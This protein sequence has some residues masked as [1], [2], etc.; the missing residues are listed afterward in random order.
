MYKKS[1]SRVFLDYFIYEINSEK[2]NVFSL[3]QTSRIRFSISTFHNLGSKI[4]EVHTETV[5]K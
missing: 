5:S 3:T 2:K 4:P 1:E